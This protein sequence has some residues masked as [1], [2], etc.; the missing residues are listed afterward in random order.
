LENLFIFNIFGLGLWVPGVVTCECVSVHFSSAFR[1]SGADY[2]EKRYS[3]LSSS[4]LDRFLLYRM[5]H[6]Y[7]LETGGRK[8][9]LEIRIC[10]SKTKTLGDKKRIVVEEEKQKSRNL[11]ISGIES[12][13]KARR[14]MRGE[15]V[16][17][18]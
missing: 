1:R 13:K 17:I 2:D 6:K 14:W 18:D 9:V 16:K 10:A 11:I 12:E 7:L 4:H 5:V 3:T 15:L 8:N